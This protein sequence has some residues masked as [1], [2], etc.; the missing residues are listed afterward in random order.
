MFGPDGEQRAIYRKIHMFDVEV[1]DVSYRE[2]EV[3]QAGDAIA[4]RRGRRRRWSG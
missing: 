3:E 2:S 4:T 1:G